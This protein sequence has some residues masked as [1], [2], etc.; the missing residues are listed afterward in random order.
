MNRI[1]ASFYNL[2]TR[3]KLWTIGGFVLAIMIA[4]VI[5]VMP[6]FREIDEAT[7][8][9]V[10]RRVPSAS[11]ISTIAIQASETNTNLV[12]FALSGNA[13]YDSKRATLWTSIEAEQA[14]YNEVK[15]TSQRN[16]ADRAEMNEALKSLRSLQDSIATEIRRGALSSA[17]AST[18]IQE[19]LA[20]AIA[21]MTKLML[22][23]QSLGKE[24]TMLGHLRES[25]A[26]D[27]K[28][29]DGAFDALMKIGGLATACVLAILL[30]GGFLLFRGI[31][32]PL[33]LMEQSMRAI[34]RKEFD[35]AIPAQGQ[36]DEVG[37]MASALVVFRD[38]LAANE[39]MRAEADRMQQNE[40]LRQQE[41]DRL[42]S[43][44]EDTAEKVV[45]TISS[46]SAAAHQATTNVHGLAASGE[47]LSS[48]AQ[49]IA[50]QLQASA[51]A[52]RNAVNCVR[53][54]DSTVQGLAQ[55]A[56]KIG[57]VIQLI[58]GLAGQTNLLALNATIEAARAGEAGKGFA[59]VASEVKELAG[60]TS[61]ATSEIAQVISEIQQMTNETVS[62]MSEIDN[63]IRIIDSATA[64]ISGSVG[65]QESATGE[66]AR[67]VHQAAQGT[68]E[69]SRAVLTVSNVANDT[70]AAASQVLSA[71]G[72][73]SQQ[74][75]LM[76]NEV[77]N[78]L[79]AVK[80]A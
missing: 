36:R 19:K 48:S 50:R 29:I 26:R 53:A 79:A 72:E 16:L 9:L 77:Q 62:A 17:Q 69:V 47:E 68:E 24:E 6:K 55:A 15:H 39:Q 8:T 52:T 57:A 49:E 66:I 56:V 44:F 37:E 78:F 34:A 46:A 51:E 5:G 20:P 7:D 27:T 45:L 28:E 14:L 64:Q 18:T 61:R 31:A 10:N 42:I 58:N 33:R 3:S 11:I 54:T 70:A 75:D 32:V 63:A 76:R 4:G 1:F 43:A 74:A 59:V 80:A 73:L 12:M 25:M 13:T 71:S 30:S 60:Q 22:G 21:R 40:A 38:G 23:D 41:I 35:V 2:R 65:E 67:S